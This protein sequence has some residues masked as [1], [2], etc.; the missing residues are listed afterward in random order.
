MATAPPKLRKKL[1]AN[2]DELN[3]DL[4]RVR[5]IRR[6]FYGLPIMVDEYD[7]KTGQNKRVKANNATIRNEGEVFDMDA[8]T[9]ME[10][11]DE[12]FYK[13]TRDSTG[14]ELPSR[15]E[16]LDKAGVV[17]QTRTVV[18]K[19]GTYILPSWVEVVDSR[20]RET[21]PSGHQTKFGGIGAAQGQ[22]PNTDNVI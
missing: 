22:L 9:A 11:V 12:A 4:V 3:L 14:K 7:Q 10:L 6:G 15:A 8:P 16:I 17:D 13:P 1:P 5:A 19:T 20:M 18:T 21:Q 2:L